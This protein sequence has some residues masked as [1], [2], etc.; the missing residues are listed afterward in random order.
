MKDKDMS[1][2]TLEQKYII[3]RPWL[4][5]RMDKV[6][7]PTGAIID[8]YYVLEFPDWVNTIAI[9][10]DGKFVLVR[11]YRYGIGKTVD[12]LCA[13]VIDKGETPLEAAQR[14]LMEETGFGGGKWQEWMQISAN[15]SSHTNI[16]HSF[17]ATDV[18]KIS[19]QHLDRGEDI[20]VRI[21]TRD[22]MLELLRNG[23]MWQSVM[24]APLW[25]YFATF[26]P[27]DTNK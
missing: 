5:A 16:V 23:E 18:E 21:F 10:K 26:E 14:E 9:T 4:T 22:E 25:K 8:E 12:E 13:G 24:A 1:W 6:E 7:L 11:Q 19:D 17:L 20:E 27:R 3:K 2:K 15:P